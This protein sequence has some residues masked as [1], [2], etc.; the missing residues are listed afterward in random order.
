MMSDF[1]ELVQS[2]RARYD[3]HEA[4]L[5]TASAAEK[6]KR[7]QSAGERQDRMDEATRLI[8]LARRIAE[9]L[10]GKA[11]EHDL[12]SEEIVEKRSFFRRTY[13][14]VTEHTYGWALVGPRRMMVPSD[15]GQLYYADGVL[16]TSDGTILVFGQGHIGCDAFNTGVPSR[17]PVPVL[18]RLMES[19]GV[20]SWTFALD[21]PAAL[22]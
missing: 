7:R 16:R 17:A 10:S 22:A 11:H 6:A 5:R 12:V 21:T 1:E 8:E 14:P 2:A 3:A 18:I 20:C 19:D 9:A 4:E 15:R 13:E